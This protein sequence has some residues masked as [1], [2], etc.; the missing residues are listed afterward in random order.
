MKKIFIV[1]PMA[2]NKKI[3]AEDQFFW[4]GVR[5]ILFFVKHSRSNIASATTK[6]L[7]VNSSLDPAAFCELLQEIWYVLDTKNLG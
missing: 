1:R 4:S 3:S 6:L 5:M 7:K 2:N